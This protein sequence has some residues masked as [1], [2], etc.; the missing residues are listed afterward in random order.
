VT[1][2]RLAEIKERLAAET[3][4]LADFAANGMADGAT[5]WSQEYVEDVGTL[6]TEVERAR[7]LLLWLS[8]A[9]LDALTSLRDEG[10]EPTQWGK[11]REMER[12]AC[13]I[14]ESAPTGEPFTPEQQKVLEAW[15]AEVTL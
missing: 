4:H 12:I 11:H 15:A 8:T 9:Y 10:C 1:P 3:H 13:I 5:C 14:A 6:V 2:E 7:R